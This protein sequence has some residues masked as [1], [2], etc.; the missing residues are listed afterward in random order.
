MTSLTDCFSFVRDLYVALGE[1]IAGEE[2]QWSLR[3]YYKPFV[4]WL[5]GGAALMVLGG[6]LSVSDRRYRK[7]AMGV[8]S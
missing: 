5:W 8:A 4:S 1:P 7:S 3:V 6:L 2:R